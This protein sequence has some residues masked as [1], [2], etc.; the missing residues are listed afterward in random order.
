MGKW[1]SLVMHCLNCSSECPNRRAK[2]CCFD[3]AIEFDWKQKISHALKSGLAPPHQHQAKLL[4]S[5]MREH[6]CVICGGIEWMGE[7]IPLILDHI[8]GDSTDWRLVN[9]RLVCANC[10]SQLPTH[11]SKNRG[12]GRT[13]ER[14]YKRN[15][16]K[17]KESGGVAER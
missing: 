3:C 9:L 2:F 8:N 5:K 7:P 16:K 17:L 10:N 11:T 6:K 12:K 15:R 1:Q 4:V 14:D 13:Y